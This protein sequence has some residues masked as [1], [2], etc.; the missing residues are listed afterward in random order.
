MKWTYTYKTGKPAMLE[1]VQYLQK[2]K[3]K[4]R[5][6]RIVPLSS[7]LLVPLHVFVLGSHHSHRYF[8]SRFEQ[9][10]GKKKK[11]KISPSL[12]K[13]DAY[14]ILALEKS[15]STMYIRKHWLADEL[16]PRGRRKEGV[17]RDPHQDA[18]PEISSTSPSSSPHHSW[19]YP[20]PSA[21]DHTSSSRPC[22]LSRRRGRSTWKIRA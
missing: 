4:N 8:R 1:I 13:G 14:P 17:K 2:K 19:A 22:S 12:G 6:K 11:K 18:E 3:S 7:P 10:S 20:A 21:A 16:V 15:I 5:K 9:A